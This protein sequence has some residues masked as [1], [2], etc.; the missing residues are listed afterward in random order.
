MYENAAAAASSSSSIIIIIQSSHPA[1][2]HQTVSYQSLFGRT[3]PGTEAE[4]SS[5]E[6]MQFKI[7]EPGFG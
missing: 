7:L 1:Y 3:T 2:S 6:I 5:N 4:R